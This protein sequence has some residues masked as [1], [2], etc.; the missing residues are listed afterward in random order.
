M[1]GV[2]QHSSNRKKHRRRRAALMSEINVTPMV[3]VMLV[4]LIIFMVTAPLMS[5]GIKVNLPESN[6]SQ[7]ESEKKEE[8]LQVMVDKRGDVYIQK[9]RVTM[10]E[11]GAKL[12]EVTKQN[13]NTQIYV[14]GDKDVPYGTV[15]MAIST[16]NEAGYSKVGLVTQPRAGSEEEQKK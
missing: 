10:A 8:P 15:I 9:T 11:L 3:D 4:L 5:T 13:K 14:K 2:M 7:L 16:I 12:G 1:A 6:V